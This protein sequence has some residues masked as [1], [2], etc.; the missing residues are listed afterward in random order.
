MSA[1]STLA[2]LEAVCIAE[3]KFTVIHKRSHTRQTITEM[4]SEHN[5]NLQLTYKNLDITAMEIA[6]DWAQSNDLDSPDLI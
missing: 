2:W 6:E 4:F 3:H 1:S 5:N